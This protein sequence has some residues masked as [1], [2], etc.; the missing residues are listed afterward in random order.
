MVAPP[1]MHVLDKVDYSKHRLVNLPP[2]SLPPLA[3]SSLRLQSKI[4]GLTTNNLTYARHGHLLGWWD[5]YPQ[6]ETTPAPYNDLSIYGRIAAWGY[7]QIIDSTVPDVQ[8]GTTVYGFLPI[9]TLPE[10]IRIEHTGMKNQIF[11]IDEHRKH[12]WKIYNRYQI[13]LSL[14]E[15]E[16]TES[17][18][19][20]G[21]DSLM[22]GLF[23]TG[24]NMNTYAFAW[25]NKHRIHP[26][27]NG[28]WSAQDANLDHSTVI[29]LNASGKTGMAFAYTLR[30]NR[31]SQHQP[32]KIIGVGSPASKGVLDKSGFY[33]TVML[34]SEDQSAKRLVDE[35]GTS[36]VI[37]F[38]FGARE[39][40]TDT[41][42]ATL[43]SGTVPFTF[44]SVGAAV[45]VQHPDEARTHVAQLFE[46]IQVNAGSLREKGIEVAGESYFDRFFAA[47]NEFKSKGG[48]PGMGLK[49]DEGLEAWEKG[50]EAFCRD[51]VKASTGLVY[52]I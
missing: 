17:P 49:W 52:R 3:P 33:D 27:G 43:S 18:D 7:A 14:A 5:I 2:D 47:W 41:W 35:S 11:A 12:V 51:E 36:R 8:V 10:D 32:T 28:E 37:L 34:N 30:Y 50:W 31:P 4:L 9:S 46:R 39:G 21:W 15:L 25:E 13:C 42:R 44:I 16:R 22:Q 38:D 26:S 23:A 48:I 29:I 19:S 45:K 20:L 1:V 6:P 40:A 24:Y